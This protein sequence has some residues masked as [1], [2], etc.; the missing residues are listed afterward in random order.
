MNQ[1]RKEFTFRCSRCR[2]PMDLANVLNVSAFHRLAA[3]PNTNDV[4]H[5]RL[6]LCFYC[7]QAFDAFMCA[8]ARVQINEQPQAE[9]SHGR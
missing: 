4:A 2:F 8:G 1:K 7:W 3:L 5:G 9:V 6:E